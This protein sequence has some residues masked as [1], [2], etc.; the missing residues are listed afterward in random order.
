MESLSPPQP[1]SFRPL[2][3]QGLA[4]SHPKTPTGTRCSSEFWI[5]HL[6]HLHTSQLGTGPSKPRSLQIT[7]SKWLFSFVILAGNHRHTKPKLS[8]TAESG[9]SSENWE[10]TAGKWFYPFSLLSSSVF[11]AE[12]SLLF[13]ELFVKGFEVFLWLTQVFQGTILLLC[14]IPFS[15]M[16]ELIQSDITHFVKSLMQSINPW[17]DSLWA[18]A[19]RKGSNHGKESRVSP[20]ERSCFPSHGASN[21]NSLFL[22]SY[23]FVAVPHINLHSSHL[24]F[25]KFSR[26]IYNTKKISLFWKF[27]IA[28]CFMRV[29]HEQQHD[30]IS[31]NKY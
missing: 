7:T 14:K 22:G 17:A 13:P 29:K 3:P 30:L 9:R 10:H 21:N 20:L 28:P 12:T 6:L 2:L 31:G 19:W 11:Q 18:S 4:M 5:V 23:S 1:G 8:S 25:F 24:Y 27:S 26:N 16:L 15:A